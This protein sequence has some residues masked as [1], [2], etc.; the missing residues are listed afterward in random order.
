[1]RILLMLSA[2]DDENNVIGDDNH[3]SSLNAKAALYVGL[4][5]TNG[6]STSKSRWHPKQLLNAFIHQ[7]S[8]RIYGKRSD[9]KGPK[10]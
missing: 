9:D 10:P 4:V 7:E 1:M 3:R 2:G 8:Q 5:H 6:T